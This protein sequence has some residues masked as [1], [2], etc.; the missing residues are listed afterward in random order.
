[1]QHILE[2]RYGAENRARA[3][4]KEAQKK[5]KEQ[6]E[7][8]KLEAKD[9]EDLP[10][11]MHELWKADQWEE[12]LKTLGGCTQEEQEV[13][14]TCDET[15]TCEQVDQ[16]KKEFHEI[17][18]DKLLAIEGDLMQHI[19]SKD[20]ERFIK[21]W[22][23]AFESSITSFATL[24]GVEGDKVQGHGQVKII[25]NKINPS[26]KM[27]HDA[28]TLYDNNL[29]KEFA[30]IAKQKRRLG[31]IKDMCRVLSKISKDNTKHMEAVIKELHNAI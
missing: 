31:A 4:S 23:K 22:S 6:K 24:N 18:D 16:I 7:Q 15:F 9:C 17:L 28:N 20:S 5:Q 21:E 3:A 25:K 8:E 10:P 27:N 19:E 12:L 11:T 2:S 26:G 1:M 29:S 14:Q 30:R 13:Q